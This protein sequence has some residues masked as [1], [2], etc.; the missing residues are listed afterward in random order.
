MSAIL[1]SNKPRLTT[2]YSFPKLPAVGRWNTLAITPAPHSNGASSVSSVS[3][4]SRA[5][6][7]D[8]EEPCFITKSVSY[9]HERAHWVN[10]VR[11]DSVLKEQVVRPPSNLVPVLVITLIGVGELIVW[12]TYCGRRFCIGWYD[13]SNKQWVLRNRSSILSDHPFASPVDCSL[14]AA[15]DKY[16][17]FAVTA[18]LHSLNQLIELLEKNNSYRQGIYDEL[19]QD[20]GRFINVCTPSLIYPARDWFQSLK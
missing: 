9:T 16:A 12:Q 17:F 1:Q 3:T 10:A 2:S 8:R 14:H 4:K 5:R 15:L 18:S 11:K 13:E 6:N 19:R 20:P 7:I